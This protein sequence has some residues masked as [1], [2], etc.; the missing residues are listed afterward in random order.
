MRILGIHT[1]CRP[2]DDVPVVEDMA[3]QVDGL[4]V[5]ALVDGRGR[6]AAELARDAFEGA[7]EAIGARIEAARADHSSSM[8]LQLGRALEA[9]LLDAHRL[10][11]DAARDQALLDA[12]AA[13]LAIAGNHAAIAHVGDVRAYLLRDGRL[14]RLTDDHTIAQ[15]RVRSGTMTPEEAEKSELRFKVTQALGSAPH[16]DVDIAEVALADGDLLV[17]CSD[18]VH[19]SVPRARIEHALDVPEDAEPGEIA[20]RLLALSDGEDDASVAVIRVATDADADVLADLAEVMSQSFLFRDLTDRQR[21]LV[22]PYLEHRFLDP[23]DVLFQEGERGDTFYAV[24]D[25]TLVIRRGDVELTELGG[26]GHF[27]ELTLARPAPRS[28]TVEARTAALVL[29]LSRDRFRQIVQRRPAIG[30]SIA[31]AAL[32]QLGHRVRD[33]TDR[34]AALESE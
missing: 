26:G 2:A 30:A 14:R 4:P 18:G 12:T 20:D 31:I 25:G 7:A 29:G 1:A 19:A 32:D 23:G 33:L 21:A 8:R 17:L 27:G 15:A 10:I 28:A 5:V 3:F 16:L 9:A 13:A 11:A 6:A 24:V 34:L 22:A